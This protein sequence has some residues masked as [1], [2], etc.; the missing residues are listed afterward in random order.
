VNEL[1]EPGERAFV[2][3]SYA[4]REGKGT[5]RAVERL[6]KFIGRGRS[7]GKELHFLQ[8]DID[9]FFMNIN[10]EILCWLVRALISK[11]AK[12]D[13]WKSEA[14]GLAEKIIWHDPTLDYRMNS[15]QEFFKLIPDRKS[16][17][18]QPPGKGLPIGN[19]TSQ[20]FANLYLNELDQFVK[21]TLKCRFYLRY[22]DD[23]ILL[24][25]DPAMLKRWMKEIKDFTRL[26]LD[27]RVSERKIRMQNIRK[28]VDFLGYFIKPDHVLARRSVVARFKQKIDQAAKTGIG[29]E[30]K[31]L[32]A[33]ASSYFGHFS[34]GDCRRLTAKYSAMIR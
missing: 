30:D 2:F 7:A 26:C 20:F 33:M 19:Y 15:P 24:H 14:I 5:H 3:D 4:C 18:K 9:G 23:F 6:R 25:E 17:F 28:G 16:L 12:P 32:K 34:H 1:R 27:L 11:Q 22:V 29:F 21:R 13:C 31:G 10:K 8:L